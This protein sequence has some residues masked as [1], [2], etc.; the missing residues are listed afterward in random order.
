[1]TATTDLSASWKGLQKGGACKQKRFFCHCC[2]LQSEHIHHLN[3]TKCDRYCSQWMDDN[4]HCYHHPVTGKKQLQEMKNDIEEIKSKLVAGFDRIS[5]TSKLKIYPST[6]RSL[7]SDRNS[8]D[9]APSSAIEAG[10]FMDLLYEELDL[11]S[12]DMMGSMEDIRIRLKESLLHESKMR[13]LLDQVQHCEGT[14]LAL[15]LVM[16]A[17]PCILHCENRVCIKII[18]M[19]FANC[20]E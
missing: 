20:K 9:Y 18:T 17:V 8:I 16:Q 15:F 12:L 1:M 4:W 5:N 3:D 6:N 13:L 7:K 11:R 2:P 14:G 10:D 19:T